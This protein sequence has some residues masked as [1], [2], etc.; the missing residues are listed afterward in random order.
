[1]AKES[2]LHKYLKECA[3][4]VLGGRPE[5]AINGI[6]DV[7]LPNS[8]VEVELSGR[9]DRLE[10]A[11]KKLSSSPCGGGILIVPKKD[12]SSARNLVNENIKIISA[13]TFLDVCQSCDTSA[14]LRNSLLSEK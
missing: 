11:V 1:M 7:K 12:L 5:K 3:A 14:K 4:R 10:H 8:C 2:E 13:E 6:V 9:R